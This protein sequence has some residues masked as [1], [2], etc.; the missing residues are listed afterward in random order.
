M[1]TPRDQK[2]ALVRLRVQARMIDQRR[3]N[4]EMFDNLDCT[5]ATFRRGLQVIKSGTKRLP[6]AAMD[7]GRTFVHQMT[8]SVRP[9]TTPPLN[10]RRR[11]RIKVRLRPEPVRKK[12]VKWH[13]NDIKG[14]KKR[15]KKKE[16]RVISRV[17]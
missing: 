13:C 15:K 11:R 1:N 3:R 9:K 10:H 7:S 12:S 5:S 16:K 6:F 8:K 2:S 4:L 14:D 17:H